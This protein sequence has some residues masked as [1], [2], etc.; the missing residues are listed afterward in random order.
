LRND[1]AYQLLRLGEVETVLATG[2]ATASWSRT[3]SEELAF[4]LISPGRTAAE[5]AQ[6]LQRTP[7]DDYVG[8]LSTS[9]TALFSCLPPGA[10]LPLN[11]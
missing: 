11:P 9:G 2:L 8:V 3:M 7:M 6:K 10:M 5:I 1:F 4:G